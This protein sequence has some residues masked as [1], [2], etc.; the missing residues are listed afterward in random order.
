MLRLLLS[1]MLIAV[2]FNDALLLDTLLQE[3]ML[4]MQEAW[5]SVGLADGVMNENCGY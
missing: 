1:S 2:E 4:D 3:A 5:S